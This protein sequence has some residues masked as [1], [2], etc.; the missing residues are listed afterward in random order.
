VAALGTSF[1]RW[2]AE[3]LGLDYQQAFARLCAMGLSVVRL[4][5]SWREVAQFGWRHLDWL[6]DH[7]DRVGQPVVLTVGMKA[8]GW[9]E[10]YLP[11]DL[12]PDDP[13]A[14]AAALDQVRHTVQRYAARRSLT[15]W[16]LENEPFN[17]SGPQQR[18]IRRRV[19][20]RQATLVRSLDP[21][22]PLLVTTFGHFSS[23]LDLASSR[24][25]SGWRRRLGLAVPAEREALAV[26]RRGDIL[27]VDIYRSI[28]WV[29]PAGQA[30]IS[31]AA[32]DQFDWVRHWRKVAITQGK[33]LWVTEAQAEPWEAR[34]ATH[35]DPLTFAPEGIGALLELLG[36]T[37]V[38]T[39]LLWGSE[40]WLWRAEN[41][42]RRWVDAVAV[43]HTALA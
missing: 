22:R 14:V 31:T 11:D 8:L 40:Y 27:G 36:E 42:D 43:G 39:V 30:R 1:T 15:G 5:A 7:A 9:P 13:R 4:S 41:G 18:W 17:R 37:G 32:A 25:Q 28:G 24:H 2:R 16:Q 21:G 23:D 10:F 34:R 19:V 35:G 33:R 6:L 12:G 38:E 29:D 20:R 26:L 3:A